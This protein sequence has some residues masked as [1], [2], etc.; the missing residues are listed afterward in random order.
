MRFNHQRHC[1]R[2]AE[3][4]WFHVEGLQTLSGNFEVLPQGEVGT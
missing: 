3:P 1:Y 4:L 2:A